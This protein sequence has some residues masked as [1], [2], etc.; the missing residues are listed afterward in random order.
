[1]RK[2]SRGRVCATTKGFTKVI[3]SGEACVGAEHWGV[4]KN[5]I[6]VQY[7]QAFHL[8]WL[9]FQ[10]VCL[11]PFHWKV[12]GGAHH[13]SDVFHFLQFCMFIN[14]CETT[15]KHQK[16]TGTHCYWTNVL[17]WVFNIKR[18]IKKKSQHFQQS[19]H[20]CCATDT[21]WHRGCCPTCK[22]KVWKKIN[23]CFAISAWWNRQ[24]EEWKDRNA[25][26]EKREKKKEKKNSGKSSGPKKR[27]GEQ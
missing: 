22:V 8:K 18:K 2:T 6:S 27:M 14:E 17:R 25:L 11:R 13:R 19:S 20:T 7:N 10:R 9:L 23:F 16:S 1:M 12:A 21:S 4:T 5:T 15:F 26:N 24:Q 3:N